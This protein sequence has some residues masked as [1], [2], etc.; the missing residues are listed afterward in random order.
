MDRAE[1][2]A[3]IAAHAAWQQDRNTGARANL[4][5]ADLRG[6]DLDYADLRGANIDFS[7]WPLWCGSLRVTLD[8]R[9]QA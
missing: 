6:A 5:G 4:S 3:V 8:E 9:Q 2:V 1:I 7:A